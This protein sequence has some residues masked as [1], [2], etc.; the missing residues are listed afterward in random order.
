MYCT[1]LLSCHNGSKDLFDLQGRNISM[2]D[3]VCMYNIYTISCVA[4]EYRYRYV[5][6]YTTSY[7][8]IYVCGC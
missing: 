2:Y 1:L 7:V 4:F 6:A 8:C 5:Y 3:I